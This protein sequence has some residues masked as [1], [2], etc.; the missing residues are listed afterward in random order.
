MSEDE[1]KIPR[2]Q[3]V[4]HGD[5]KAPDNQTLWTAGTP[6]SPEIEQMLMEVND[7]CTYLV[8]IINHGP[9]VKDNS[10]KRVMVLKAILKTIITYTFITSI[11]RLGVLEAI[12]DDLNTEQKSDMFKKAL[13]ET[14]QKSPNQL[15][16]SKGKNDR[17]Y[18]A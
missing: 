15:P 3:K 10:A 8:N 4:V 14:M 2:K 9:E 7:I 5:L 16:Q 17:T 11:D 1:I 13:E 6:K 18:V 12:K